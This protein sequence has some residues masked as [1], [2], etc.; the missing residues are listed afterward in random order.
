MAFRASARHVFQQLKSNVTKAS[1]KPI[2][3]VRSFAAAA[4]EDVVKAVFVKQQSQ[5][6]SYL[7][8]LEKVKIPL[9]PKSEKE[10]KD[11]A[12]TVRS[13]RKKVNIPSFEE[14]LGSLLD[15]AA[16]D[17]QDLRSFFNASQEIRKELGIEDTINGEPLLFEALDA[18]EK[19]IGKPLV[20]SDA[21]GMQLWQQ[22]VEKVNAKLGLNDVSLEALEKEIELSAVKLELSELQKEALKMVDD[23]KRREGLESVNVDLD[24]LDP[25]SYL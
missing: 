6:R 14:K 11:F 16:E 20:A 17:S 4:E 18:V 19:K 23:N 10:V 25:K 9:D 15:A 5:F 24:K 22:Q 8:E 2:G 1:H 12:N 3:Q 13:I 21:K 7:S